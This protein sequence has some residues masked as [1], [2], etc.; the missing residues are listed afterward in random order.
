M[1]PSRFLLHYI[2]K[3]LQIILRKKQKLIFKTKII[4]TKQILKRDPHHWL[5]RR[6]LVLSGLPTMILADAWWPP[7]WPACCR[8]S[9]WSAPAP[10]SRHHHW[11]KCTTIN[12]LFQGCG[13]GSAFIFPPRSG[14]GSRSEKLKNSNRKNERKLAIIIILLKL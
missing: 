6:V 12:S 10:A 8:P 9:S 13:F 14:T 2:L 7:G 3:K 11:S 1:C 4:L 5:Y